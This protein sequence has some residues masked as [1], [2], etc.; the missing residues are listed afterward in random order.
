MQ[1]LA[2]HQLTEIEQQL[3]KNKGTYLLFFTLE[4]T[5]TCDVG[6]FAQV[7][8]QPGIYAYVGSAFGSG[9]LKARL[10]HHLK[11]NQ[12]CHWHLDY[13]RPHMQFIQLWLTQ[14]QQR[15]EHQW[16]GIMQAWRG[17]SIPI[18]GLGASDCQCRGHFFQ[19]KKVPAIAT[20][21]KKLR[22]ENWLEDN[23][24]QVV[25]P[26]PQEVRAD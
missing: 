5:L 18:E 16:A 9:G 1:D 20:F 13:L 17:I 4:Q 14:D 24:L 21:R 12:R 3:P 8:L 23:I 10:R 19:M 26:N 6:K 22:A 25:R 15:R 7:T 11:I 2:V